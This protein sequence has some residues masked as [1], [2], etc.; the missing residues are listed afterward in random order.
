M[1]N[2]MNVVIESFEKLEMEDKEY[3]FD[4]LKK[5]IIEMRRDRIYKRAEEAFD[6][7]TKGNVQKG[8]I[9]ELFKD[10]EG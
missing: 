8:S 9:E 1:E 4:L 5:H 10:L 7:Y 3:V 6:N 2:L